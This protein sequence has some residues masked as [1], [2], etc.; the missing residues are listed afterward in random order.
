MGN[1]LTS[2]LNSTGALRVYGQVF[3]TIQNNISNANTPDYAT[4]TLPMVALPF[5]PANGISGG[6][7]AGPM[8]SSRSEYL[9]QNVRNQQ[10]ALGFAQQEVQDLGQVQPLFDLSSSSGVPGALNA[11]FNSFS[12]LSVNPNDPVSRQAVITQAGLVAQAFNQNATGIQQVSDNVN[13][14]TSDAVAQINQYASQIA[15]LNQQYGADSA[16]SADAGL[17][18]QMH[19]AL[20][21]LSQVANFTIVKNNQGGY[22]VFLGGQTALVVGANQYSLQADFSG[23]QTA[24]LDS[25]GND[26]SGQITQ[27]SLGALLQE[28]NTIL[29]GYLTS[30]NTLAQTF[31][32]QVNQG[33]ANGVDQNGAPGANLFTYNQ[34]SDAAFSL[35]VSGITPDQIAAASATAPGGND[36]AIAMSQLATAPVVNGYSFTQSY[37]NLGAQVG[38][39][40]DTATQNQTLYQDTLTQAEQQ[41]STASGVDLNEQAAELLQY[42]QSYQAIGKLVTVLDN[43]TLDVINLIGPVF[44]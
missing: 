44:S 34:P 24:I 29:P 4:Q 23:P 32:D 31:A 9:E 15:A 30:L 37:G 14:E 11:F 6:V 41:R 8:Q 7:E 40:I 19:V 18:A 36:N 12:Q 20:E 3:D 35:A 43:L 1:L 26:V 38:T 5:D 39:D 17:D 2:L 16:A 42:Q 22:N 10:Q 33:L 21:N 28:E 27:G 25:Q 13:S